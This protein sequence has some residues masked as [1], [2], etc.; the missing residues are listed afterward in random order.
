MDRK[1]IQ[2]QPY[3][4]PEEEVLMFYQGLLLVREHSGNGF[5]KIIKKEQKM[6][7]LNRLSRYLI[8]LQKMII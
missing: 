7:A 5:S 4:R 1:R 3:I 8:P 2:K 6:S